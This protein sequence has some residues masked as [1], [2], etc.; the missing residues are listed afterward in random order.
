MAFSGRW[1][2][3]W[4][5]AHEYN[6]CR[7][8]LTRRVVSRHRDLDVFRHFESLDSLVRDLAPDEPV[9][10]L[11]PQVI[12]DQAR[13]FLDSFPGRVL[14]AVK[15]N[16]HEAVLAWLH[17]AGIRD[18]DTASPAEMALVSNNLSGA[19]CYFMHPVKSRTGIAR[20]YREF[21]IRHFVVDHP[22]ELVKIQDVLG[23]VDIV[24]VVRLSTKNEDATF[25]L[26]SKFGT[27]PEMAARLLDAAASF[28][29]AA[30]L[31]FHVGSQCTSPQAFSD[32]FREV[33]KA[34]EAS[35]AR[36]VCLDVGGGFPAYY[37]D[38]SPPPLESYMAAI[39][40]GA[41]LL[42]LDDCELMCEPGRA[43]VAE[44]MSVLTRVQL[45]K[46]RKI[47]LNDGIY[48]SFYT[49]VIGLRFPARLVRA[50]ADPGPHDTQFVAYGPTCDGLDE[51]PQRLLLPRDVREGDWIEIGCMGAYTVSLRTDFNG[52]Y[53]DTIVTVDKPFREPGWQ[54][55]APAVRGASF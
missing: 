54:P 7:P 39:R 18:Y 44:G 16:P 26:S 35:A 48:G 30:G 22:D 15:S 3:Q 49:M 33:A 36:I 32:A 17:E 37:E 42:Q 9:Y 21:G 8:L 25:D 34:L 31:C 43:L 53:P 5:V 6:A 29:Y 14:Y 2:I 27:T 20:A 23:K 40:E 10:C 55:A 19:A 12:R 52:F 50:G 24:I 46:D 4:G 47:Y 28:G 45:R 41:G 51:L 13:L 38:T 1:R 11:R